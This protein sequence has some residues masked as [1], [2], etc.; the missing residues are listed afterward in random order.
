MNTPDEI[1]DFWFTPPMSDHWF[2]STTA[3]DDEI[4]TRFETLWDSAANH[5]QDDWQNTAAG[6][7]ALCIVL[8]QFPLNMFRGDAKSFA[9]EQQAVA[10]T[11][12]AVSTGRDQQLPKEHLSF[13][14]MPLMHSEN[15]DDQ[16]ES[17]R[18]FDTAGLAHNTRFA[19]HH[20]SI[21]E[22]FGRFPHR[23]AILGR[24]STTEEIAYLNSKEAF[25]G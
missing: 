16:N 14:Y 15:M 21:V 11:K 6:C 2:N 9:T 19:R 5:E 13:L 7:L 10:I 3:I 4:R 18:L 8:D 1:L 20:R 12:H 17:V 24:T 25:T 23:N 22:R